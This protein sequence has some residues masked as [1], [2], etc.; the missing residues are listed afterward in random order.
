MEEEKKQLNTNGEKLETIQTY[1][2]DMADVV[3][4]KEMSVVKIASAEHKS[5][6]GGVYY[7]EEEKSHKSKIF[8]IIGG[9]IIIIS[10]VVVSYLLIQKT[11]EKNQPHQIIQIAKTPI[12]YDKKVVVNVT[13]VTDKND[14]SNLINPEIIKRGSTE[15]IKEILLIKKTDNISKPLPLDNLLSLLKVTAPS[16]LVRSFSNKYMLG[17]YT[18]LNPGEKTHLFLIIKIKD[19][20]MAY[21]GMLEWEKTIVYD[22]FTF[23]RIDIKGKNNELL[24]KSFQDMI[25]KNKDARVLYNKENLGVLFYLFSD[26]NTLIISDSQNAIKEIITRLLVQETKPI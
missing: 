7:R 2:S 5:K 20:N 8:F 3:R 25:I 23:F 11:K 6:D 16:S 9:I 12:S 4:D 21:A 24:D 26:R 19:Y 13:N 15:S 1:M 10:A 14:L 17:T 22:L 18:P